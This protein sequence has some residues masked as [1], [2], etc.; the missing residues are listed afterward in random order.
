MPRTNYQRGADK[1][2][3][4]MNFYRNKGNFALRSAGSHSPFDV[5]VIDELNKKVILIQVKPKSLSKKM[6]LEILKLKRLDGIYNLEFQ[7]IK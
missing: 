2:R 3:R 7:L 4:I 5:V 1:E 6:E